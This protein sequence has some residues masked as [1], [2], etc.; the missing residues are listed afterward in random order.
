M[1]ILIV[2]IWL[3]VLTD[4]SPLIHRSPSE[5]LRPAGSKGPALCWV[6]VYP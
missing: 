5:S 4:G 3:F 2:I 6:T 1:K